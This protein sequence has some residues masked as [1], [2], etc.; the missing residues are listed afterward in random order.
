MTKLGILC[1]VAILLMMIATEAQAHGLRG[2]QV[3]A[4]SWSSACVIGHGSSACGEPMWFYDARGGH[5]GKKNASP[6]EADL[7][8]WIGD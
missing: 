8:P 7:P 6:P 4:R 5:A 2:R 3:A 1:G